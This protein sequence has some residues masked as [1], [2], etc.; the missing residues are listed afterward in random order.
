MYKILSAINEQNHSTLL[1]LFSQVRFS[2]AGIRLGENGHNKRSVLTYSKWYNWN[3]EQRS[4]FKGCFDASQI[5]SAVVG[6][7]LC[8]PK[9][10]GFLDLMKT[11]QNQTMAGVITA[12]S[13]E[14]D[15]SIILDGNRISLDRGQGINFSLK[16]P[17][18]VTPCNFDQKWACLMNLK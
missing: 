8:F 7:F 9:D 6:W 16:I 4:S 3:R 18:E 1:N 13:L 15:Q 2:D 10:I 12:Y 5:E 17:H 14:A 11:W